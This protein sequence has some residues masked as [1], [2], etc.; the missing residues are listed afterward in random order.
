M[1]D[2]LRATQAETARATQSAVRDLGTL[3]AQSQN[4]SGQAAT[5]R[6]EAIDRAGAARQKA[7]NDALAAQL[8]LLENR[9]KGLEDSNAAR[10]DGMRG[11]LVQGL[12]TIRTENNRKLDEIRGTVDEKLE[13]TL[14]SRIQES[15]RTV[16]AQL[17]QVYKAW[18]RCRRW[19]PMWAG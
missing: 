19:P 4:Q 7:A 3:L 2:Q 16:S 17:E 6:L 5:A 1:A 14:Q 15:F 9:L 8:A 11:A 13:T 10:L 12:N 18:A